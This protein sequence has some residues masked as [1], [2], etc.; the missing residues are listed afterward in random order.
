MRS[1]CVLDVLLRPPRSR[2]VTKEH[3]EALC[4]LQ[5]RLYAQDRRAKA[6]NNGKRR[7]QESLGSRSRRGTEVAALF[8]TLCETAKIADAD[9]HAYLLRALYTTIA[10]PGAITYAREDL[11]ISW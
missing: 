6:L 4:E 1:S 3:I 8:N 2:V 10:R 7:P 5:E 9:P 11:R